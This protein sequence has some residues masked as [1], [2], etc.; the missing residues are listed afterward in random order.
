M[1]NSDLKIRTV[2]IAELDQKCFEFAAL[3][4]SLDELSVLMNEVLLTN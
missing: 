3:L 4:Q 1:N 2:K